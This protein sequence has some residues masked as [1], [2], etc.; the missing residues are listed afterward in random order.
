MRGESTGIRVVP[1]PCVYVHPC[2][3]MYLPQE[4]IEVRLFAMCDA[5]VCI[6]PVPS[7]RKHGCI[8][9]R[10]QALQ[11]L[12]LD[13]DRH[14]RCAWHRLAEKR[15]HYDLRHEARLARGRGR[16]EQHT[17]W[18]GGVGILALLRMPFAQLHNQALHLLD[19]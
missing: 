8:L 18:P 14:E 1:Y 10:E 12:H 17:C 11:L 4:A 13:E 2:P 9:P 19:L 15:V 16:R 5:Q 7:M 6:D 3:C